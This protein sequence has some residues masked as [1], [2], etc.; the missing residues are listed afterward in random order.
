MS[1]D[2]DPCTS[3]VDLSRPHPAVPG[4]VPQRSSFGGYCR[5]AL[6]VLSLLQ[7]CQGNNSKSQKYTGTPVVKLNLGRGEFNPSSTPGPGDRT[8]H[9]TAAAASMTGGTPFQ[10]HEVSP[11]IVKGRSMYRLA[12]RVA[13]VVSWRPARRRAPIARFLSAAMTLG[14]D[15]VRT[16]EL[17]SR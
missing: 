4:S 1:A 12:Q 9:S 14:P 3:W 2:S 8:E 6:L 13:W 16:A 11:R 10:D 7:D 17:S 5:I 15:L